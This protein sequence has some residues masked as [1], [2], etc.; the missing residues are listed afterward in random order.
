MLAMFLYIVG[1]LVVLCWIDIILQ[2]IFKK[3]KKEK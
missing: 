2:K 3:W 1:G